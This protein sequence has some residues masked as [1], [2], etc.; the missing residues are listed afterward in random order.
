MPSPLQARFSHPRTSAFRQTPLASISD[1]AGAAGPVTPLNGFEEMF[2]VANVVTDRLPPVAIIP[3]PFETALCRHMAVRGMKFLNAGLPGSVSSRAAPAP[4]GA[5]CGQRPNPG[6]LS[7]D[8][9]A[10]ALKHSVH[11]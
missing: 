4:G 6:L 2:L 3:R 10:G 8:Q 11:A 1:M 9:A 7:Q 5:F